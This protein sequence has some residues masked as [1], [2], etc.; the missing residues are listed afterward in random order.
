[1]IYCPYCGQVTD[2]KQ[3]CSCL[4]SKPPVT[5]EEFEQVKCTL[6]SL[7]TLSES[8][9]QLI[10]RLTKLVETPKYN[11]TINQ[12]VTDFPSGRDWLIELAQ[13]QRISNKGV[14]R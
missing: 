4:L 8:L 9:L 1:M 2:G 5:R 14:K 7:T 11:L 3:I 12:T 13:R 10:K 6:E